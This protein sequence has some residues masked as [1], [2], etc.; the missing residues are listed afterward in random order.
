MTDQ[1]LVQLIG[2]LR[3]IREGHDEGHPTLGLPQGSMHVRD[4]Q[5]TT[6]NPDAH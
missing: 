3:R 6:N 4:L 1:A 5:H 2:G